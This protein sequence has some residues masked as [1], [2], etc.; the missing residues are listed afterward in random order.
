ME[1]EFD[2]EYVLGEEKMEILNKHRENK[3]YDKLV[4]NINIIF[5]DHDTLLAD[6]LHPLLRSSLEDDEIEEMMV[7]YLDGEDGLS[8]EL[9]VVYVETCLNFTYWNLTF[10]VFKTSLED[11]FDIFDED[12]EILLIYGQT[13]TTYQCNFIDTDYSIKRVTIEKNNFTSPDSI[14]IN[15]IFP[16]G[17]PRDVRYK[18][19]ISLMS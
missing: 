15:F 18:N 4:E 3:E 12:G 10:N 17:E 13:E 5:N 19:I 16:D 2:I 7:D 1:E 6:N 9:Y 11:A 8:N 14:D